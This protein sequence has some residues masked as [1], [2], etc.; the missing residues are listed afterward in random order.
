[1]RRC[2]A[3]IAALALALAFSPAPGCSGGDFPWKDGQ[4]VVFIGDSITQ[5]GVYIQD[6]EAYLYTRFPDRKYEII[7][8]G[9]SAETASE[10]NEPGLSQPRPEILER[11]G[12]ALDRTRPN[13]VLICYGMNDGIYHPSSPERLEAYQQGI[14]KVVD[15]IKETGADFILLTPPPFDP[16]PIASRIH[17]LDAKVFSYRHPFDQYDTVLGSY[18]DWLVSRREVGWPVIDVHAAINRSVASLRESDADFTVSPDGV[19]PD[20]TGHWLIAQEIL[21]AWNVPSEV[22]SASIDVQGKTPSTGSITMTRDGPLIRLSWSTRIPMPHDPAWDARIADREQV[23][24]RFNRHRLVVTGLKGPRYTLSEGSMP[25]GTFTS[26]ELAGGISL[27]RLSDLS[28]N[29]RAVRLRQLVVERHRTINPAWLEAIGHIQ[30]TVPKP[31]PLDEAR[32]RAL[33]LESR[34]RD[35]ARPIPITLFLAPVDDK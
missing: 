27:L 35:L 13:L 8:L 12:R 26:R 10:L 3:A 30:P 5:A 22:D 28:T 29:R 25:I 34:I 15:Q 11:L 32:T 24:E 17:P 6:I 23:D 1:M 31:L 14:T 33:A 4:R 9:L 2:L 21:K 7:D 18:S 19:H 20:P 16:K